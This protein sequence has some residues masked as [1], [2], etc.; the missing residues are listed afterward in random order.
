MIIMTSKYT[1]NTAV[2]KYYARYSRGA[3]RIQKDY[4]FGA[5][6]SASRLPDPNYAASPSVKCVVGAM[7]HGANA[8]QTLQSAEH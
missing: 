8:L 4:T 3:R 6:Q 1:R 5:S 2:L 7:P